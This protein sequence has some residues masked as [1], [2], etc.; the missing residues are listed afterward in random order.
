MI[1]R[2]SASPCWCS[3]SP[4]VPARVAMR[5]L[6]R[7][8]ATGCLTLWRSP[9][10]RLR[11]A[12][13]CARR[14]AEWHESA[15]EA[16]GSC[17]TF[18]ESS[19]RRLFPRRWLAKWVRLRAALW[20]PWKGRASPRRGR[21]YATRRR[22]GCQTYQGG[23]FRRR[24]CDWYR[25]GDGRIRVP[26]DI[27]ILDDLLCGGIGLGDL[28]QVQRERFEPGFQLPSLSQGADVLRLHEHGL[29]QLLPLFQE[30]HQAVAKVAGQQQ[31][32]HEANPEGIPP[33]R[34]R[35]SLLFLCVHGEGLA[36]ALVFRLILKSCFASSSR[37]AGSF[38]PVCAM[39]TTRFCAVF[40]I[41]C[42]WPN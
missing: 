20:K 8:L 35:Q 6:A 24:A 42:A 1:P 2:Q 17:A 29:I 22:A 37:N 25:S 9:P 3:A 36:G 33:E 30:I 26:L 39:R 34:F 7:C 38:W 19:C 13:G 16:A 11:L 5:G 10:R 27:E 12:C 21:R 15:P 4:P 41:C 32:H 23:S 28:Q 14:R 40:W 31:E 18:P